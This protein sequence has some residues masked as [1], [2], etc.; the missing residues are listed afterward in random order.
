MAVLILE[1]NLDA[2]ANYVQV[3]L[4]CLQQLVAWHWG[5]TNTYEHMDMSVILTVTV[6]E[7]KHN[8]AY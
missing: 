7:K 5:R 3:V 1:E 8:D 2:Q 4:L 6:D